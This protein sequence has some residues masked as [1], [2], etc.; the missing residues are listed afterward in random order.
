MARRGAGGTLQATAP[1][2]K[3]FPYGWEGD[4]EEE[5]SRGQ[6]REKIVSGRRLWLIGYATLGIRDSTVGMGRVDRNKG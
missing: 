5:V 6:G 1:S 3:W 4:R 2:R